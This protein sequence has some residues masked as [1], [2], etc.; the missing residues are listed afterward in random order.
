MSPVTKRIIVLV[1]MVA[2]LCMNGVYAKPLKVYILVGQSNMEGHAQTKTFPAVAKDPKTVDM[3]KDMVDADG[4]PVV[5]DDVWI[6]YSFGDFSGNPVGT[7]AGKLTSGWG[8]QHHVGTGKIG[9]EFTFGIY[10]NKMLGEPILLIKTAWGGKS[11]HTDFRPPSAGENKLIPSEKM[12]DEK[13]KAM[14]RYYKLMIDYVKKILADPKA[15]YPAY[16]PK[17][18][19]EL[20]GFVWFQ[21]FNDLVG[22][23]PKANPEDRKSRT[24]DYSD[25]SRVLGCFIRDVRK[26]LSAPKL[27]FVIGVL[28]VGGKNSNEGG[29]AFRKAMSA[30]AEE[31]EFKGSVVNVLTENYWPEELDAVQLKISKFKNEASQ[32]GRALKK[33]NLSKEDFKKARNKINDE[34]QAKIKEA[35]TEDELFL[36]NT[37]ISNRGFHYHGSAKFFGQIGKA[38]AEALVELKKSK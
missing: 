2:L 35:L 4:K 10:M 30:P 23:Y 19:Y 22:P 9:P 29:T 8:S 1:V 38:F 31:D 16:D 27:P 11:L 14:G 12:T 15:V 6:A 26:D 13:K 33:Q 37:G 24:K 28:G 20:E 36:L 32:K 3:Y 18:G 21:G 34:L 25:Y 5:C 7:K 17:E